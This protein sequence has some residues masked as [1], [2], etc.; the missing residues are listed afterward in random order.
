MRACVARASASVGV[1]RLLLGGRG[2]G[3]LVSRLRRRSRATRLG[4]KVASI[5]NDQHLTRAHAIT[6]RDAD[7][8]DRR[9]DARHDRGRRPRLHHAAGLERVGDVGHRAQSP[10]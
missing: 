2:G 9:Q 10:R 8:P 5:E 7:L 1:G 6:R 4:A 3:A